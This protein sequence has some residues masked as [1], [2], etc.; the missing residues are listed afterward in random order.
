MQR[1]IHPEKKI[2]FTTGISISAEIATFERPFDHNY[3]THKS[4]EDLRWTDSYFKN[5]IQM[6]IAVQYKIHRKYS[7][8]AEMLPQI[9]LLTLA[10]HSSFDKTY[11]KFDPGFYSAEFN[12]GANYAIS[13]RISLGISYRAFQIKKIDKILFNDIVRDPRKEEKFET[14]NPF[15][16]WLTVGYRL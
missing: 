12:A 9:N 1:V 16:M 10:K 4:T 8:R 13:K 2:F 3:F 6:P 11:S 15:K 5:I 14:Y 7:L